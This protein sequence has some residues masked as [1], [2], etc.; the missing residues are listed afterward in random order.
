MSSS[1]CSTTAK[2]QSNTDL[3]ASL[4][5]YLYPELPR[6]KGVERVL[7]GSNIHIASRLRMAAA[8]SRQDVDPCS[9]RLGVGSRSARF[10]NFPLCLF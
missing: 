7:E 3:A 9:L 5:F 10:S 4:L 2:L 1:R 6:K 8:I